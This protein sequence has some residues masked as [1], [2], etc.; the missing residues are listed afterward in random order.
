MSYNT[1]KALVNSKVYENTE[2]RITGGDMNDVLQSA[3]ASLGAHYQMGG[4]VSPTDQITVRDEPVVFLATTPGTY[5]YF[6][7]LVVADGEVALLVWSGTAWSKQT[8][9][10]ST[11]TEVNQLGQE[12]SG[13]G[14][15]YVPRCAYGNDGSVKGSPEWFI[16]IDYIPVENGDTIVWNPGSAN[17]GGT[18]ITY[19]ANKEYLGYYSANAVER[20][21]TLNNPN[22]AYLRPSFYMDNL[23]SAKIKRNG[24]EVWTPQ[25]KDPGVTIQTAQLSKALSLY[26]G[27][28]NMPYFVQNGTPGVYADTDYVLVR[29]RNTV[30]IPGT[31]GH[32]Y[33]ITI[34]KT[35]HEGYGFYFE[36]GAY[37]TDSPASF[38]TNRTRTTGWVEET[39]FVL[40]DNEYGFA[41]NI[42]EKT[43]SSGT[44][45]P[46]RET[47]FSDGDIIIT[48]ITDSIT[49]S[50]QEQID[51][52]ISYAA[53]YTALPLV[54]GKYIYVSGGAKAIASSSLLSYIEVPVAKIDK[55]ICLAGFTY[56]PSTA[57]E[58][59]YTRIHFFDENNTPL[60][61]TTQVRNGVMTL[62]KPEG[63]A[64][65]FID[66]P[67]AYIDNLRVFTDFVDVS[68]E[69]LSKYLDGTVMTSLSDALNVVFGDGSVTIKA[70]GFSYVANG[71][72]FHITGTEDYPVDFGSNVTR[73]YLL[74]DVQAL[75]EGRRSFSDVLKVQDNVLPGKGDVVLLD[76]YIGIPQD[77]LFMPEYLRSRQ[78]A[79]TAGSQINVDYKTKGETF[80]ALF[81][82]AEDAVSFLFFTDP[83]TSNSGDGFPKSYMPMLKKIQQFYQSLPFDFALSGG[84]W[85]NNTDTPAQACYKLGN[86]KQQLKTRLSP[87]Y[88]LLGNH[89]TNYQGTEVLSQAAINALS[90]NDYG[91]A[92]YRVERHNCALYLFDS[93]TDGRSVLSNYE[94]EQLTWFA[95]SLVAE[96]K[97][98]I[99]IASHIIIEGAQGSSY[100]SAFA[101]AIEQ[102]AEAYNNRG[103]VT[104]DGVEHI[105]TGV[106]GNGRVRCFVG[107]HTHYDYVNT[108]EPIPIFITTNA[109]ATAS[110]SSENPSP[111]F[112]MILIDFT[113]GKLHAVRVG[114][115][116][117]RTIDL[118]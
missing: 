1:L 47:D 73:R 91:K 21:F 88:Q 27:E 13:P 80:A 93:G 94:K 34:N 54:R 39:E 41:I 78:D 67:V 14:Q 56:T 57:T 30:V 92:Y 66:A 107:G 109:I 44:A 17:W 115:G 5:T 106:T 26:T 99:V 68:A 35:P 49:K 72:L 40:R 53:K 74:L 8:P 4:L 29:G 50:L 20:T 60:S 18:L 61:D 116:S 85:L 9:D 96:Q 64:T 38:V 77:G 58:S 22:V 111:R 101:T 33:K 45:S 102:I 62:D 108:T 76:F 118:A 83:H 6:G 86:I 63:A 79:D 105:F 117:D 113:E 71:V 65:C 12:V 90:F 25:V 82:N 42:G 112:D 10:I 114:D 84:D 70:N 19:N 48:D 87:C 52:N 100:L 16:G 37:T 103:N 51:T 32:K 28:T 24:V 31:P 89:D 59:T 46:L 69:E 36:W 110:L 2:Q 75:M 95:E 15:N 55:R 98:N 43:S 11:R 104:I 23:S 81:A 7:G 3:I 97:D